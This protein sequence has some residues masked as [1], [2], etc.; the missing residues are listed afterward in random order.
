[1]EGIQ[2][3]TECQPC[4]ACNKPID[5]VAVHAVSGERDR[6]IAC[7]RGN[8][9]D[10][11]TQDFA[12]DLQVFARIGVVNGWRDS[13]N[14]RNSHIRQGFNLNDESGFIAV[15]ADFDVIRG[16]VAAKDKRR[17]VLRK[18]KEKSAGN[19][20]VIGVNGGGAVPIWIGT[21]N[22]NLTV[23]VGLEIVNL[24]GFHIAFGVHVNARCFVENLDI[25]G[26][27]HH[28]VE[29][30]TAFF[31]PYA[32][33]FKADDEVSLFDEGVVEVAAVHACIAGGAD[34]S[35]RRV[36]TGD[37]GCHVLIGGRGHV[38]TVAGGV[39]ED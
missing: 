24:A 22:G 7:F 16:A 2:P 28:T 9:D 5:D 6:F 38:D 36:Q 21:E 29:G 23:C 39:F 25:S 27:L 14:F 11:P 4:R 32:T 33:H 20:A 3:L 15:I 31:Q 18:G 30:V 37:F 8:R 34:R 19:T 13:S 17:I 12:L 35:G 26:R 10:V 1:M